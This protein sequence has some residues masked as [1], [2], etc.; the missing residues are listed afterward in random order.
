MSAARHTSLDDV[1]RYLTNHP[2]TAETTLRADAT[3]NDAID[4]GY[5]RVTHVMTM[6]ATNGTYAAAKI[7]HVS[8]AAGISYCAT[9]I[10]GCDCRDGA[11]CGHSGCWGPDAT[12]DC[13]GVA[14]SKASQHPSLFTVA[15]AVAGMTFGE[16]MAVAR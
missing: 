11:S 13:K 16:A 15:E 4:D 2:M 5:V 10:N 9:C 1:V 12:N 7:R 3:L 6:P 14:Y 8:L